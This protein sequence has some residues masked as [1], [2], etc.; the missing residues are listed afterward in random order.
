MSMVKRS[1]PSRKYR[2]GIRLLGSLGLI[3]FQIGK[4]QRR[5]PMYICLLY[6]DIF[7]SVNMDFFLFLRDASGRQ[8][9]I[10]PKSLFINAFP[11]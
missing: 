1:S 5:Q 9:K 6:K 11:A 2:E 4:S 7:F 3:P 10:R 8:A